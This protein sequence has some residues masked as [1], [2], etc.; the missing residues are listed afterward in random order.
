MRLFCN[1]TVETLE[2]KII[3]PQKERKFLVANKPRQPRRG[4]LWSETTLMNVVLH[5][6]SLF[7]A[8][9]LFYFLCTPT[10]LGVYS[11]VMNIYNMRGAG[12]HR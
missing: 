4:K 6:K 3:F 9:D 10:H 8:F 11:R 7:R 1:T 5:F 2:K 12:L